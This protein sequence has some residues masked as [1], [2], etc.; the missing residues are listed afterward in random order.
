MMPMRMVD[1]VVMVATAWGLWKSWWQLQWWQFQGWECYNSRG[2]NGE[3]SNVA[4]VGTDAMMIMAMMM[5]MIA[6]VV[7]ATMVMVVMS[8]VAMEMMVMVGNHDNCKDCYNDN[9]CD[10]KYDGNCHDSDTGDNDNRI[11]STWMTNQLMAR[12]IHQKFFTIKWKIIM[13]MQ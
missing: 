4:Y 9:P 2:G 13:I 8:T 12:K 3:N 1:M 6:T 7:M 11:R 5:M 10:D